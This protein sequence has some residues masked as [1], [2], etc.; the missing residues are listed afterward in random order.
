MKLFAALFLALFPTLACA[1]TPE[2]PPAF[3][4]GFWPEPDLLQAEVPELGQPV[5]PGEIRFTIASWPGVPVTVVFSPTPDGGLEARRY[6]LTP[7]A[8]DWVNAR[9]MLESFCYEGKAMIEGLNCQAPLP[10]RPAR[11]ME[12]KHLLIAPGKAKAFRAKVDR[13][14]LCER[15]R[16]DPAGL[17]GSSWRFETATPAKACSVDRWTPSA[18]PKNPAAVRFVEAGELALELAG[19]R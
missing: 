18:F 16:I 5:L 17:D 10:P 3:P 7:K 2:W 4:L 14:R 1:E 19:V 11:M 8:H 13:L 9:T 15:Q 6:Q 12:V